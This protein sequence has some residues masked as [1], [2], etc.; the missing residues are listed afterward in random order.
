MSEIG[1]C[2]LF[3]IPLWTGKVL[4][5]TTE[6]NPLVP[7]Y[8]VRSPGFPGDFCTGDLAGVTDAV[9]SLPFPPGLVVSPTR[10]HQMWH[11][12]FPLV[13]ASSV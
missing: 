8:T 9:R 5:M 1:A 2:F 3:C 7:S 12:Q 13:A 11:T 10:Q 4:F 6:N